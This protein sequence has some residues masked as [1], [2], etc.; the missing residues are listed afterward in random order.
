MASDTLLVSRYHT[1]KR[2]FWGTLL[3]L[4]CGLIFM[5]SFLHFRKDLWS[6][7]SLYQFWGKFLFAISLSFIALWVSYKSSRPVETQHVT[8]MWLVLPVIF[9]W[10]WGVGELAVTNVDQWSELIYGQTWKVCSTLILTLSIP[11]FIAIFW[12]LRDSAA[13]A[14]KRIGFTAGVSAGALAASIYCLHCPEMSPVFIG[15]WY[16]LS[17]LI[18]GVVG[19]FVGQRILRW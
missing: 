3:A 4:I 1:Q 8:I 11:F 19:S 6:V 2:L 14:P 15:L 12:A 16:L 9:L 5:N 17:V 7:L 10:I 18:S 13:I